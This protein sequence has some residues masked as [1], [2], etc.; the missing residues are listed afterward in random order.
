MDKLRIG[1]IDVTVD[2]AENPAIDGIF[3]CFDPKT[4]TIRVAPVADKNALPLVL[5]H[6]VIECVDWQ[7][8]LQLKHTVLSTL[9]TMLASFMRDNPEF[10]KSLVK[11]SKQ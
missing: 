6:E 7:C 4:T 11:T 9:A 2:I 10:V 8:N 3:A 5:L 1:S